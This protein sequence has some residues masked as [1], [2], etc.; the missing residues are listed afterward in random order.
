MW[1]PSPRPAGIRRGCGARERESRPARAV[2]WVP[3]GARRTHTHSLED[4]PGR[5]LLLAPVAQI[6]PK[7]HDRRPGP[8]CGQLPSLLWSHRCPGEAP[9]TGHTDC[10]PLE[11]ATASRLSLTSSTLPRHRHGPPRQHA[12]ARAPGRPPGPAGRPAAGPSRPRGA[13]R[14]AERP[15]ASRRLRYGPPRAPVRLMT[16]GPGARREPPPRGQ[17]GLDSSRTT[18]R[19][20]G[21]PGVTWGSG[22][23]ASVR[24][25]RAAGRQHR[26]GPAPPHPSSSSSGPASPVPPGPSPALEQRGVVPHHPSHDPGQTP[27][28]TT[29]PSHGDNTLV[30]ARVSAKPSNCQTLGHV[31]QRAWSATGRMRPPRWG[32]PTPQRDAGRREARLPGHRPLRAGVHPQVPHVPRAG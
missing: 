25:V 32:L 1:W 23:G 12:R 13:A 24:A 29:P 21:H 6:H 3:A 16:P 8:L 11:P 9:R 18:A 31:P 4:L 20:A 22:A 15:T 2:G 26:W 5:R 7:G 14:G 28:A 27:G 30:S 17:R 10:A 19:E